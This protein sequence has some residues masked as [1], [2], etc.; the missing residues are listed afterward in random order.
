M[1]WIFL[2]ILFIFVGYLYWHY[3]KATEGYCRALPEC[4]LIREA[5]VC[6]PLTK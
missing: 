5:P 1:N 2:I 3:S 4:I 6:G